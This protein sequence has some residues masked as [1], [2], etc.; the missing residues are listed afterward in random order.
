MPEE[1]NQETEPNITKIN[2]EQIRKRI[3]KLL[4]IVYSRNDNLAKQAYPLLIQLQEEQNERAS[5][6]LTAHMANLSANIDD[7][8][9]IG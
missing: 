8:I 7:I 2:D 4:K 3:A 9:N 1:I 5:K 6:K